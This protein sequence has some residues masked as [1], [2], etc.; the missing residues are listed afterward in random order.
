MSPKPEEPGGPDDEQPGVSRPALRVATLSELEA[1]L[2]RAL[3]AASREEVL[4]RIARVLPTDS[5]V[6]AEMHS[7]V[8]KVS[9]SMPDELAQAV[10]RRTGASGFSRYV[11]DAVQARIRHDLLGDLLDELDAQYGP[12][13]P[14]MLEDARFKWP[15][16]QP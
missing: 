4:D 9:V 8:R 15:D 6:R 1:A 12:I 13:P 3:D 7:N 2:Q 14:E 10:R 5:Q 11:S 16:E